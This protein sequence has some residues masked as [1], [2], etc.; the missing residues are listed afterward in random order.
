ML[1]VT[2]MAADGIELTWEKGPDSSNVSTLLAEQKEALAAH[3]GQKE[4]EI[5]AGEVHMKNITVTSVK[6]TEGVREVGEPAALPDID[7]DYSAARKVKV[8]ELVTEPLRELFQAA[9]AN[10]AEEED[11]GVLSAVVSMF[12]GK[13][14]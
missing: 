13:G 11:G 14:L 3:Q 9:K 12:S 1:D 6:T 4:K 7:F 2:S 10:A 8:G 5:K